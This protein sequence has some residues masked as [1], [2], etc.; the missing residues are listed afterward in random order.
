VV[1]A[2]LTLLA[3]IVV[4]VVVGLPTILVGLVYPSRRVFAFTS[5]IWALVM[6]LCCGV[7]LTIEGAEAIRN[8]TPKFFV[9]N[10]QSA[11][12]IPILLVAL[13]GRVRFMA[14]ASLFRIPILGWVMWRYGHVPIDREHPRAA[15]DRLDRMIGELRR[16]PI[17]FVAFPEGT[18]SL[19]GRL[20][21]FR[22]GT[23]KICQRAGL[24]V[25]PF[26]ISGSVNVCRRNRLRV[27]PGPVR[28][29][30]G[31][32]IPADRVTSMS[33][34]ELHDCVRERVA[35]GLGQVCRATTTVG[36]CAGT[37]DATKHE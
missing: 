19:D 9:G 32:P 35:E 24:T 10:H 30:F 13:S 34:T 3:C 18:R 36:S 22:K 27:R 5:R 2:V 14:K 20:L 4:L 37:R 23:M 7:R 1:S 29:R 33:A 6:L 8:D 12:D 28:L 25:V 15:L 26:S 21:P 16:R 11:L 17:S 31:E